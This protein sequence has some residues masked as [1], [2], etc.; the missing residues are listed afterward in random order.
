MTLLTFTVSVPAL[1]PPS[2]GN[3]VK[4]EY[5]N[6]RASSFQ[7]GIF[8]C[9]L[10]IIAVG[11]GGTKP[12]ISTLGAGQFDDFE[13]KERT[14]KLSF[15]NWW[16]FSIFFG[17]LFSNTIFIYIQDNVGWS[18]GY[19]L[20]TVGLLFSVLVFLLGT[21]LYRHKVAA[22]S[23]LT[24]IGQVLVAAIRKWKVPVPNDPKELHE[25]S[26]EDYAK[27]R[28][29]RINY[30]PSLRLILCTIYLFNIQFFFLYYLISLFRIDVI[31]VRSFKH[32]IHI[33]NH[34]ESVTPQKVSFTLKNELCTFNM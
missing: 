10:Y 23:P 18:L 21:P 15:F 31:L 33:H 12:N 6:K 16:M 3:G 7:V 9:A 20:P 17:T 13:P 2:C 29:F 25:L 27:T 22:E 14:Q 28:K 19:G 5:C 26:L 1:R 8:Y 11:T 34:C 32:N 24:R 30:T 4:E